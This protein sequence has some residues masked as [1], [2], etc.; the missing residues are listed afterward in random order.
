MRPDRVVVT[1]PTLDDDPGLAQCVEDFAIEQFIAQAPRS[2]R[3]RGWRPQ[4]SGPARP[5]HQP[6]VTSRRSLQA[7]T[8]SSAYRSSLMPK[9]ILQVG[10]LLWGSITGSYP[11]TV[12]AAARAA[13]FFRFLRHLPKP[14]APASA[15]PKSHKAPGIGV[16]AGGGPPP[17]QSVVHTS[18]RSEIS[19][20]LRSAKPVVELIT[21]L[22][23]KLP[24]SAS[25]R[26]PLSFLAGLTSGI[27]VLV[28][29]SVIRPR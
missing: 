14:A 20:C 12:Q 18:C 16:V 8:S 2:R 26:K 9:D 21:T 11:N 1:P 7:Y 3:S 25:T 19:N 22:V 28:K 4:C 17:P 6:A 5:G 23:I 10:P 24:P 27:D 13:T 29:V 15:D